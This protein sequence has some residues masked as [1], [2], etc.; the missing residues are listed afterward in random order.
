[1]QYKPSKWVSGYKHGP[2]ASYTQITRMGLFL[3]V[4]TSKFEPLDSTWDNLHSGG[5]FI[6]DDNK[7]YF[8]DETNKDIYINSPADNQLALYASSGVGINVAP[9]ADVSL[10]AAEIDNARIRFQNAHSVT[11]DA[12]IST[13]DDTAGTDLVIGSNL[14]IGSDGNLARWNA[15]EESSYLYLARSG[16]VYLGTG[17]TGATATARLTI[18]AAGE[19]TAPLQPAFSATN[20]SS[21]DNIATG[22][23]VTIVLGTEVFDQGADFATNTFTAPVTGRY[24]FSLTARIDSLDTAATYYQIGIVTSNRA[25]SQIMSPAQFAADVAIWNFSLA[26]L[27]DMDASDTA[28]AFIVQSGGTAQTDIPGAEGVYFTGHL[29]C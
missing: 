10:N 28:Y 20:A 13:Y 25:Y 27:A 17:S 8:R 29:A 1:M 23:T 3:N 19:I 4:S 11:G 6:S 22:S 24:Q 16:T 21:Q 18:S 9:E 5:M 2:A 7:I 12:G 26:I 14:Y 15:S